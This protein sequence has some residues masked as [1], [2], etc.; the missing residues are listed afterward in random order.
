MNRIQHPKLVAPDDIRILK[1]SSENKSN[2]RMAIYAI[3]GRPNTIW[4][5]QFSNELKSH[6]HDLILDL[7]KPMLIEGFRYL[8][9]QDGSWNGT[10]ADTEFTISD[11]P[12][13]FPSSQLRIT[14]KKTKQVQSADLKTP[15]SGRYVKIRILSDINE[16]PWASAAELGIIAQ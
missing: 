11:S 14:F 15:T 6:P 5:T 1:V 2:D 12:E 13:L 8:S 16:G 9:R 3:D 4:H 7:G 10:F